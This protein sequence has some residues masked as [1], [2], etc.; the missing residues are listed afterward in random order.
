MLCSPAK[1]IRNRSGPAKPISFQLF[2]MKGANLK[3]VRPQLT[4]ALFQRK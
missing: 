2:G 4:E 3:N 1:E